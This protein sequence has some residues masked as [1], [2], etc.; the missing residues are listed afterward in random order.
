MDGRDQ[1]H[2]R[3]QRCRRP[4]RR[5]RTQHVFTEARSA[6]L[7]QD[8]WRCLLCW[9][10][11]FCPFILL[12]A[13]RGRTKSYHEPGH[14]SVWEASIAN[15]PQRLRVAVPMRPVRALLFE[16]CRRDLPKVPL[17]SR[18]R[19]GCQRLANIPKANRNRCAI[20]CAPPCRTAR[21]T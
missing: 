1:S 5:C 19:R 2:W 21:S 16:S 18:G 7:D 11:C 17:G 9:S 20:D 14:G 4:G 6:R 3:G 8:R 15:E 13:C 12:R 10:S